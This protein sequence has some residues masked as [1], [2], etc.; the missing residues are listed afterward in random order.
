MSDTRKSLLEE[1]TQGAP[2]WAVQREDGSWGV[3]WPVEADRFELLGRPA[4][5][6][7]DAE[8]LAHVAAVAALT[9]PKDVDTAAMGAYA[10]LATAGGRPVALSVVGT[11]ERSGKVDLAAQ[12]A[13][14]RQWN[15]LAPQKPDEKEPTS[16]PK[17]DYVNGVKRT[18]QSWTATR[19]PES[20]VTFNPNTNMMF[21]GAIV[22]AGPAIRQGHLIAAQIEDS[23]R[24]P[25]TI[26]V[27]ALSGGNSRVV[28]VPSYGNVLDAVKDM[29]NG[30][31]NSSPDIIF[32]KTEGYSS[33]EAAL[34]LG[35]SASFGGFATSLN[36]EARRKE[37][38]NTL[39]VYL[40]ERAFT[41][42]CAMSTPNALIND[43]FTQE[44]LAR[45]VT[46]GAM[47][48]DNP[49][50]IVSDV[51]YGRVLTF[52][53][54]STAS[55]SEINAALEASY[56]GFGNV[57]A[58]LKARY[59]QIIGQ[60][61]IE[62]IS[63]GGDPGVIKDLLQTGDISNYFGERHTLEQYSRMGYVLKTL[64]GRPAKMSESTDY[65]QVVWGGETPVTLTLQPPAR[66]TFGNSHLLFPLDLMIDGKVT[67]YASRPAVSGVRHFSPGSADNTPFAVMYRAKGGSG[68]LGPFSAAPPRD[69][70][71]SQDEFHEV[72]IPLGDEISALSISARW[73]RVAPQ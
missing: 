14:W 53:F 41:A 61:S 56:K 46:L 71:I 5:S 11:G 33:T 27:D 17:V 24:A 18:T 43:T 37:S 55:E 34:S 8:S 1:L 49:P 15:E 72:R 12:L 70:L 38:Q 6:G 47:G 3:E 4:D 42:S 2:A 13:A 7:A 54:T 26:V 51:V 62:V 59:L 57:G 19:T 31:P 16:A 66:M 63:L 36:V 52:S 58:E 9:L 20:I 25:L 21:P 45:L 44:R 60:S 22:Q 65:D 39:I 67:E 48:T 23:E 73:T 40:R 29:V 32:R 30:R 50:L 28:D 68:W 35:L 69:F 64:D 10:V